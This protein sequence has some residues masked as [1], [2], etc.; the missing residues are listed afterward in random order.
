MGMTSPA[1]GQSRPSGLADALF[2]GT[3]QRVLGILFGQPDRSFY[4]TEIIRMAGAGRGAVQRELKRL[5][6]SGLVKVTRLGT[7]KHFQ[8]NGESPLYAEIC[9][10]A[11]KTF[12]LADPLRAALAPFAAKIKAAFV[13]GSVAKRQDSSVSDIDVMIISDDIAYPDLYD[14]LQPVEQELGR[15]INP[16]VYGNEEL[17]RRRDEGNAF[18]IRVLEQPKLW[19]MGSD[20]DLAS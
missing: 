11:R 15:P 4:A 18:V 16:T 20:D 19:L 12:G 10:I 13:F 5:E 6:E 17:K 14:A 9:S 7:Q 3:Q 2:T 1:S 8:A